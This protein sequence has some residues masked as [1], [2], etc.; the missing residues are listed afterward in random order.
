MSGFTPE[1]VRELQ[2]ALSSEEITA[3]ALRWAEAKGDPAA[4]AAF[5][6]EHMSKI[7]ETLGRDKLI[8]KHMT[9]QT[10]I[11][12]TLFALAIQARDAVKIPGPNARLARNLLN[13]VPQL[14]RD[15]NANLALAMASHYTSKVDELGPRAVEIAVESGMQVSAADLEAKADA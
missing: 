10:S 6:D 13:T 14:F 15:F 9:A 2:G 11:A 4:M 5:A 3:L 8:Q 1:Q 7:L 12:S